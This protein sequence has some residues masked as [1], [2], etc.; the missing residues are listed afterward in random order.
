MYGSTGRVLLRS[1]GGEGGLLKYMLA[2]LYMPS[3]DENIDWLIISIG[4]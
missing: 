4:L 3:F 2:G 1:M